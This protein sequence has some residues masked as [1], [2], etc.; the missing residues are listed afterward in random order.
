MKCYVLFFKTIEKIN[1]NPFIVEVIIEQIK[2]G[3]TYY[4]KW[5]FIV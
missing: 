2:L 3:Q 1:E 5:E 4:I